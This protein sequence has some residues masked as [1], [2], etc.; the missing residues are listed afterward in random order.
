MASSKIFQHRLKDLLGEKDDKK[1][2]VAKEMQVDYRAFSNAVNYGIIPKPLTLS[3]IADYFNVSITYL[4]GETD[5][6]Y[7]DK[8]KVPSDFHARFTALKKAKGVTGYKVAE[9][10]HFDKSLCSK[11]KTKNHVPTLEILDLLAEYF[12]VSI[13]YLLG[14]TDDDTPYK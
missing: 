8:A 2:I 1:H 6:E 14:R 5:D 11:W 12:K 7:F 3:K 4:I 9:D 13:D 10:N